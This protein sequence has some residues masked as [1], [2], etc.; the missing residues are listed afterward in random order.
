[1]T[2]MITMECYG[3]GKILKAL[4]D[5]V[6]HALYL[7]F[8]G[9]EGFPEKPEELQDWAAIKVVGFLDDLQVLTDA[10]LKMDVSRVRGMYAEQLPGLGV[11]QTNAQTQFVN[12]VIPNAGLF[13]VRKLTVLEDSCTNDIQR[14][15]DNGWRIVAVCPPNDTRR[16]TYIMGHMEL[17]S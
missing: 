3:A 1:M 15:L 6:Y 9:N 7:R 2:Q 17:D 11:P 10:G 5:E 14:Y 13:S 4:A 16:P 8:K 12:V